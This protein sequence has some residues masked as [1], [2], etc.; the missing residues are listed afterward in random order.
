MVLISIFLS[1][2][3][4]SL[5]RLICRRPCQLLL[6]ISP[7]PNDF[8]TNL[9]TSFNLS[10][11]PIHG[12]MNSEP[13]RLDDS[14]PLW[15]RRRWFWMFFLRGWRNLLRAPPEEDAT[16]HSSPAPPE[17]AA[18]VLAPN[19]IISIPLLGV[20]RLEFDHAPFPLRISPLFAV[21]FTCGIAAVDSERIPGGCGSFLP[22]LPP[23][24]LC[25]WFVTHVFHSTLVTHPPARFFAFPPFSS[26]LPGWVDADA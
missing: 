25:A 1:L 3:F 19:G 12:A 2:F 6:G 14:L 13:P 18:A 20:L 11:D 5:I 24:H 4:R 16:G 7:L 8:G 26:N 9:G 15:L 22:F 23:P 10:A 17:C 21:P